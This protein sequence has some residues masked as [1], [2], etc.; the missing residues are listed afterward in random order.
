MRVES[1]VTRL[2]HSW[3][4][5]FKHLAPRW[6]Q[7]FTRA[8]VRAGLDVRG[9]AKRF[10]RRSGPAGKRAELAIGDEGAARRYV[11]SEDLFSLLNPHQLD[12]LRLCL[13]HQPLD[14]VLV[15]FGL[16]GPPLV[17]HAT[18]LTASCHLV[19][20]QQHADVFLRGGAPAHPLRGRLARLLPAPEVELETR[21]IETLLPH[22]RARASW[23]EIVLRPDGGAAAPQ[24]SGPGPDAASSPKLR[25]LDLEDRCPRPE[26]GKP[27]V[28]VL[29][30]FLAVGGVERNT[31]EIMRRL[32]AN[33]DFV[34]VNMVGLTEAQGSL[35]HRVTDLAVGVFDLS[36]LAPLELYLTLLADLNAAYR[37]S[38][39]WICN[40]FPWQ[41][42]HAQDIRAIF[43]D[44]PI[45][46]QEV[47]DTRLGWIERYHEP[48]MQSYDHFIAITDKVWR[49]MV[50]DLGMDAARVSL[51]YSAVDTAGFDALAFS[52]DERS[53]TRAELGFGAD[54]VVLTWLGRFH[55]QKR[56]LLFVELAARVAQR[57]PELGFLMVGDGPLRSEVAAA[58][59]RADGGNFRLSGYVPRTA[60]IWSVSGGYV[61]TS[62]Y[63]G[64]PIA[65][66][67]AL[68]MGV[69]IFS[70]DV[71]DIG[72]FVERY[73][74]GTVFP[75]GAGLKEIERAFEEWL[76][77]RVEYQ[78]NARAAAAAVREFF[79]S[80]AIAEQYQRCFGGLIAVRGQVVAGADGAGQP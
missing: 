52:D 74:A 18:A 60:P 30:V 45:V 46:D 26:S 33:Y 56:P 11:L 7:R 53:R 67:E 71:G 59:E 79:D 32:Q 16:C 51:I 58:V 68:C 21:S 66:I 62:E 47:Y 65:M 80:R 50:G 3:R 22:L 75:A 42:D 78:E 64:L 73:K 41:C 13:A 48:G 69:P 76:E 2:G 55:P 39:V 72:L 77:R 40:G 61:V 9:S 36:E 31:I 4:M 34:V 43:R 25:V 24:G 35:H 10:L 38:L 29:P 19:F 23:D 20:A 14:F 28:F 8:A 15:S 17:R 12:A 57:H 54:E 37:P 1:I 63:E 70:A 49:K 6:L 5:G 44:V 27:I